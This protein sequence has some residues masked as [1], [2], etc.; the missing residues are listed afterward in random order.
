MH[1]RHILAAI[2]MAAIMLGASATTAAAQRQNDPARSARVVAT[3]RFDMAHRG[4]FPS[5]VTVA[6][7]A[8]ILVASTRMPGEEASHPLEVTVLQSD[9]IVQGETPSGVL[10]L[11][12]S[13]EGHGGATPLSTGRWS[14]GNEVGKLKGRGRD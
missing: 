2:A 6:D 8:G 4:A 14:L 1:T 12:L 3:Y 13:R 10:T 5:I 11:T 9:V 7:S